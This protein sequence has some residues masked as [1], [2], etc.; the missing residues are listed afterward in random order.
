MQQAGST[1]AATL[2]QGA[3]TSGAPQ[4]AGG[5]VGHPVAISRDVAQLLSAA[6]AL[7]TAT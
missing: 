4:E 5:K 3:E 7:K 1:A 2:A 6:D